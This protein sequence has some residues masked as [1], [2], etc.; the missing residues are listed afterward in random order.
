MSAR[1]GAATLVWLALVAGCGHGGH[2]A[3]ERAAPAVAVHV[4]VAELEERPFADVVTGPGQWRS[5]NEIAVMTPFAAVVESL[6]PRV[7]DRVARGQVI[8]W[9]ATRESRAS[10]RGAELMLAQAGDAAAR[11]EAERALALAR[12]EQVRVPLV[13]PSSGTVVRRGAE[14]GA[15]LT[16][17]S[18]L[19]AIVPPND[20][21]FEAHLSASD[22]D[23]VRGGQ[24]A[25]IVVGGDA[26]I[27]ASVARRLP[28]VGTEDQS[29]LVWLTPVGP[30]PA[31]EIGRFGTVRITAGAARTAIGVPDSALVEDDLTGERR[32]AQVDRNG[33]ATW[34][35]VRLGRA[36]GGWHE[37][38]DPRLDAGTR[39][40]IAG[41]RGLP[42]SMHVT[43]Q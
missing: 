28:G 8:A 3:V 41:Q 43:L 9:L 32:L 11:S 35:T 40:V 19:F 18:E 26:P 10:L 25:E 29:V 5:A 36:A 2:E 17:N 20:L 39:V 16:E 27:P 4:R 33:L 6:V 12:R 14:P 42:D 13:A 30:P 24:A 15:E 34:T 21:V 7:G 22:A 23:R 31:A 38:L 1:V 37:L